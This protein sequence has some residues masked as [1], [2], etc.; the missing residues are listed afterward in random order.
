MPLPIELEKVVSSS[1]APA[2]M[3]QVLTSW[4]FA[5]SPFSSASSRR[6]WVGSYVRSVSSSAIDYLI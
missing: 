3:N 5:T 4:L 6:F 2:M 1:V